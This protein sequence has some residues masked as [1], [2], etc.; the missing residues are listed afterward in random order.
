MNQI[1]IS[2]G[3]A[4]AS[5]MARRQ[6]AQLAWSGM[7]ALVIGIAYLI[8][9]WMHRQGWV[10]PLFPA[11]VLWCF[12]PYLLSS[13][14]LYQGVGVPLTERWSLLLITTAIPFLVTPLGFALLQMPYSRGAV[15]LVYVLSVSW[16]VLA[17]WQSHRRRQTRLACLDASIPEQLTAMIDWQQAKRRD[18]L[19]EPWPAASAS[20]AADLQAFDGVVVDTQAPASEGRKTLLTQLKLMHVRLYSVESLAEMLSGR[21][22]VPVDENLLWQL[23]G[24]AAYDVVKR[25]LDVS[26]VLLTVPLWLPIAMLVAIAVRVDSKGPALFSQ[27]RVGLNGQ[28]FRLWKFRSMIDTTRLTGEQFAQIDDPR[29]TRVGRFIRRTRL[30]ELP[31]LWNV[32]IGEMSLIG[33][34]P[35]QSQF[36]ESF[37]ARIPAYPYRHLVRPGL[38]GWAQVLQGYAADDEQTAVK[39]SYDLYYVAHY[40]PALDLLIA[41]KTIRVLVQGFGAR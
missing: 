11:T 29:I 34:R 41:W 6:Q 19:L 14:W 18:V 40:S 26:I 32:L 5:P 36:V 25:V 1:P 38:T 30:D 12:L 16:F 23:D 39:L 4:F 3:R 20:G 24:N 28:R 13:H 10:T 22:I 9:Q 21:K 35:E 7:G 27:I 2:R 31:Q 15:L 37:S 17:D 33:P 8:G